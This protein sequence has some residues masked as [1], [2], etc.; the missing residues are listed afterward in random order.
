MVRK[1]L[2]LELTGTH[3]RESAARPT[4]VRERDNL[5]VDS[6]APGG[7][8]GA[9]LVG[10]SSTQPRVGSSRG[11]SVNRVEARSPAERR[12]KGIL[13]ADSSRGATS[14]FLYVYTLES[15]EST[16]SRSHDMSH[17][18]HYSLSAFGR[19]LWRE[20]SQCLVALLLPVKKQI[21][22]LHSEHLLSSKPATK[23]ERK[24]LTHKNSDTLFSAQNTAHL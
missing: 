13:I 8:E 9:S 18:I 14:I 17:D 20:D 11:H 1:R 3:A 10:S 23:Q 2:L 4:K 22:L 19:F 12:N 7:A 15:R 16:K 24:L 6:A 21:L 5:I